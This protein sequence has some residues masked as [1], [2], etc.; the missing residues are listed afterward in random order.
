MTNPVT[1]ASRNSQFTALCKAL[2]LDP[3]SP[4][5]LGTLRDTSK[6]STEALI[7]GVLAIG[8]LSTFR[9]VVGTDGWVRE[10]EME[11]QQN[12][13]LAKGLREAGVRCVITGD[14]KD[15]VR[16]N[17]IELT[18]GLVLS[19]SPSMPRKSGSPPQPVSLLSKGSLGEVASRVSPI[20]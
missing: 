1:P 9:G 17:V 11:F 15:E 18:L 3:S 10:D 2:S 6:V 14:V 20:T 16:R 8:E 13:G 7:A 19:D 5:I 4:D 12:G